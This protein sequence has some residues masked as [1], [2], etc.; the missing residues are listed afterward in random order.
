MGLTNRP[1]C[2]SFAVVFLLAAANIFFMAGLVALVPPFE[3]FDETAHFSRIKSQAFAAQADPASH[4]IDA[5]VVDYYRKGPMPYGWIAYDTLHT[6]DPSRGYMTYREFFAKPEQQK[7][8]AEN[9]WQVP[10]AP[11]YSASPEANWQYQHPVV[12]YSVMA[13][14]LKW[15][16]G[17]ASFLTVLLALRMLSAT[18][19]LAGLGIGLGATY[20]YQREKDADEAKAVLALSALYPFLIPEFFWEFARLTNDSLCFLFFGIIWA[21]LLRYLRKPDGDAWIGLGF[22]MGLGWLTKAYMVPVSGGILAFLL[23][24]RLRRAAPGTRLRLSVWTAPVRVVLLMLMT[25]APFYLASLMSAGYVG[26]G[27]LGAALHQKDVGT[28]LRNAVTW[29]EFGLGVSEILYSFWMTTNWSDIIIGFPL[30]LTGAV[31][32]VG[33]IM[34]FDYARI[35]FRKGAD[36]LLQLPFWI[37][38]PLIAGL[39]MHVVIVTI[40]TYGQGVQASTPGYYLH[41]FAPALAFAVAVSL[42][43]FHRKKWLRPLVW[44][45]LL[46]A[47]LGLY[48]TATY[49]AVFAG[50]AVPQPIAAY[51]WMGIDVR[52]LYS[53]PPDGLF[54]CAGQ[55]SQAVRNLSV[56]AWPNLACALIGIALVAL[57]ASAVLYLA[58]RGKQT[59]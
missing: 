32:I 16:T 3:G 57:V 31:M 24:H 15:L 12:Y 26:S 18:F 13:P 42:R 37:L 1:A 51:G 49:A 33:A 45:A 22:F 47:P 2:R 38:V 6:H 35:S 43:D 17:H 9:Y 14:M 40:L 29:P 54:Q 4:R 46:G 5:S 23:F 50:C 36:P 28:L 53:L 34:A 11:G 10:L 41:V 44:A 19:A 58:P 56:I 52:D 30:F 39:L 27:E 48:V 21:F 7:S 20:R 55:F 59:A 25:A 8:Y